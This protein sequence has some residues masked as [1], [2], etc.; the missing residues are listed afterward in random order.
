MYSM[1][2]FSIALVL[3]VCAAPPDQTLRDL[4]RSRQQHAAAHFEW[5]ARNKDRETYHTATYVYEDRLVTNYGDRDGVLFPDQLGQDY[6]CS[7]ISLLLKE[8]KQ[9]RYTEGDLAVSVTGNPAN[10]FPSPDVRAAGLFPTPAAKWSSTGDLDFPIESYS[11]VREGDT[12]VITA[13]C[14][15]GGAVRWWLDDSRAGQPVRAALLQGNDVLAECRTSYREYDGVWFPEEVEYFTGTDPV[16]TLSVLH[17]SFEKTT[18]LEELTLA[19][20]GVVPGINVFYPPEEV[21]DPNMWYGWDGSCV[22]DFPTL[23]ERV[24]RGEVDVSL[25]NAL[26]KR[27]ASG[28][29]VG[30]HPQDWD[31]ADLG[32]GSGF[33]RKPGLWE[34]YVRRFIQ[35]HRLNTERARKAWEFLRKAQKPA[36]R[37]LE[38]HRDELRDLENELAA[39]PASQPASQPAGGEKPKSR[40]ER[41]YEVLCAPIEKMFE[42]LLKPPLKR[43]AAEQEKERGRTVPVGK[44]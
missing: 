16:S 23:R 9:W 21:P 18:Q 29:G 7:P 15:N 3:P 4:V 44:K 35:R 13:H 27:H 32:L 38:E 26:R 30:R 40:A 24:N 19:D 8:G 33:M 36:Y 5:I 34:E 28:Q 1:S 20:L 12:S 42:S 10:F 25:F 31:A 41:K 22:V 37:Y 43:L 17:A 6:S 39:A 11:F 2:F 14:P